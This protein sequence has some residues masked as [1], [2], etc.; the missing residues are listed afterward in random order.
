M[1]PDRVIAELAEVV[2]DFSATGL[3]P[4]TSRWKFGLTGD[5][6]IA[7]C[8]RIETHWIRIEAAP[9]GD[10]AADA[11][12]TLRQQSALPGGIKVSERRDGTLRAEIPL[13]VETATT[14][15]WLRRHT[16]LVVAGLRSAIAVNNGAAQ[17]PIADGI[18]IDPEVLAE[19][20]TAGGWHA[21]VRPNGEVSVEFDS[22]AA[23]RRLTL[24]QH[25]GA[26]RAAV[27]LDAGVGP[28]PR[29]QQALAL[30]L[31]RADRS[32]RWV[33]AFTAAPADTAE[34]AG[35]EC[36]LAAPDE[37]QPLILALDA[38]ATACE[39]YG[40]EAEALAQDATLAKHYLALIE[41]V[42]VRATKAA[43]RVTTGSAPAL[44][45]VTSAAA[46]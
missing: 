35:F 12:R 1:K 3:D 39:L 5:G 32:L 13:L 26:I 2:P 24:S 34:T 19:R 33:R 27:T 7:A 29:T 4:A 44:G 36:L 21:H 38:L 23:H 16:A 9:I 42:P 17:L 6:R 14:R 10:R 18:A 30:F 43:G 15:D 28:D 25:C 8:M 31:L 45:A 46:A 22:R 37:D 41:E 40:R 20:C 11:L